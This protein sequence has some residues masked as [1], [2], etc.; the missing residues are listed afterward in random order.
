LGI[1]VTNFIFPNEDVA[2]L[3]WEHTEENTAT[4][5]KVNVAR[6]AYLTTGAHLKL[7]SIIHGHHG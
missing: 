6:A 3:S 1:E 4:G 7:S 2:W 5:K